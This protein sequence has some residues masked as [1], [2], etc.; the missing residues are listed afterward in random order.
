MKIDDVIKYLT[1]A[2][3]IISSVTGWYILGVNFSMS[4]YW[5]VFLFISF[6]AFLLIV[7]KYA[8]NI[9]AML[10]KNLKFYLILSAYLVWT[11]ITYVINYKSKVDILYVFKMYI[12]IA[13]FLAGM[14]LLFYSIDKAKR[15][16]FMYQ[17][18]K[19]IFWFGTLLS[20]IGVYQ[21]ITDSNYIF[22]LMISNWPSYNPAS[23]Y[24]NVNGYGGYL[25]IS[26]M[27]GLFYIF[28][29]REAAKKNIIVVFLIFQCYM[30]YLTISRT[31]IIAAILFFIVSL[32]ALFMVDKSLL[33]P[34]FNKKFI[35]AFL[36]ANLLMV[37]VVN[38]SV[39]TSFIGSLVN[40]PGYGRAGNVREAEDMYK[41]K[42]S[43]GFNNRQ[44]IWKS[45]YDNKGEYML[46]GDGL[47]YTILTRIDAGTV[48]SKRSIGVDRISYH[49][50]LVRYFASNGLIGLILFLCLYFYNPVRIIFSDL[51]KN[52][53]FDLKKFIILTV[54]ICIFAYMQ[55]EEVYLGE[56]GFIQ[57][58]TL[59]MLAYSNSVYQN[60]ES[61]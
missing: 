43:K 38:Y 61:R 53:K 59:I 22:G 56:I 11:S 52:K 55:M 5:V 37:A 30:L 25:F 13:I 18:A 42:N 46:F 12:I 51:I 28:K 49:N 10:H 33:K 26:I 40:E 6:S 4:A 3:V 45:V 19:C 29:N 23:M 7:W 8:G 35:T 41:E 20:F 1:I 17:L 39:V 27:C 15:D 48:I 47:K 14:N 54:F 34:I 36:A 21:Y 2:A 58:C 32:A 57:I 44:I 50:T 24:G 60:S 31:S 16:S 9:K